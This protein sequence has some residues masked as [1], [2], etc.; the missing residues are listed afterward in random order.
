MDNSNNLHDNIKYHLGSNNSSHNNIGYAIGHDHEIEHDI[1][2]EIDTDSLN[3]SINNSIN[4]IE[5]NLLQST[6]NIELTLYSNERSCNNERSYNNERNEQHEQQYNDDNFYIHKFIKIVIQ[7]Y[8]KRNYSEFYNDQKVKE[9]RRG[10]GGNDGRDGGEDN[11]IGYDDVSVIENSSLTCT[12]DS[13]SSP[14]EIEVDYMIN[15]NSPNSDNSSHK[16]ISYTKLSYTSVEKGIEKYYFNTNHRISSSLDIIASYLKGQKNLYM[17]AKFYAEMQLN[18]LMLP[19]IALSSIATVI[20]GANNISYSNT[21]F[22]IACINASIAFLLSMVNYLKLDAASE[23]HKISSHQYDK[24]QSSIEFTSGSI[25]LFSNIDHQNPN[26]LE[27]KSKLENEMKTKLQDVEKKIG[28]IKETNQF[29]IPRVIRYRFPVIYNTNVFSLIKKIEDYRKKTIAN[30]KNIKNEL[31][32]INA[33][34][35]ANNYRLDSKYRSRMNYLFNKKKLKMRDILVLKSAFSLIDQMFKQELTNAEIKRERCIVLKFLSFFNV[36]YLWKKHPK[37]IN[38]E[39]INDFVEQLVDPFQHNEHRNQIHHA[40]NNNN[41]NNNK[42][43]WW[44]CFY[45]NNHNNHPHLRTSDS[46]DIN[47]EQWDNISI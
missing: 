18:I 23:A 19:A 28:E 32:F 29:I 9:D 6:D 5:N 4:D 43:S 27:E 26:Y 16:N 17:E 7:Y 25:L 31:R 45:N 20:S 13:D 30:L 12:N 47:D 8:N 42:S 38:P 2:H 39:K 37:E 35:K 15:N 10:Y 40:N 46:L 41:N 21:P 3:N 1:G 36:S 33:L 24:L 22:I 44:S 11:D 34:Q 14:E